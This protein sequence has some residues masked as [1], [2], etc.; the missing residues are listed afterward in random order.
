METLL[1]ERFDREIRDVGHIERL[2]QEDAATALG[3]PP[4]DKYLTN[5]RSGVTYQRIA[6]LLD[7][8]ASRDDLRDLARLVTANVVLGNAD[9]HGRNYGL[10]L[11]SEG[12]VRLTPAYDVVCT[13]AYGITSHSIAVDRTQVG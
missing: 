2:H 1:I 3:V 9:A 4:R 5:A 8:F 11:C 7:R 10:L 12:S 6:G 13:L